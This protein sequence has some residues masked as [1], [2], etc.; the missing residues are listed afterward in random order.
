MQ[1]NEKRPAQ[2][3]LTTLPAVDQAKENKGQTANNSLHENVN[4]AHK[5]NHHHSAAYAASMWHSAVKHAKP[6]NHTGIEL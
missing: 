6:Q 2:E 1:T 3:Q 5:Y 4:E